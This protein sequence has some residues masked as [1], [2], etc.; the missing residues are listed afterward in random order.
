MKAKKK[1]KVGL[2][3]MK[4][5]E[6]SFFD[7]LLISL[8]ILLILI[9]LVTLKSVVRDTS[10]SYRFQRQIFWDI[11]ALGV[12]FYIIFEKESRLKTYG[13]YL[14]ALSVLLLILVL[15]IGKT[16]YGAKRWIDIGPFDLQPSELFKFSI[17]LLL[18]NIFSK[19]KNNKAFLYSIFAVFPAFLVF[20][21]PDLGMTLLVLFVWFVMLLA[22][23]VDRRYIF[24]ILLIG[25]LLA[26]ISFFFVLKDYQRARIISLFNPE[27]HFQYGAYNVI[28]SKVVIANGGLFGTGYGLGTGTNMHIV[29]MQ[30][31]DFIFSAYAEQF[32][33]IGSLVLILI[34]GTIIFG[35]LLRIGRYK[36]SFWEYVSIG[37]SS[38]FTF[39]VIENIGMNL[40][41]LPVTGIPLPF[42]SYGGTSTVIFGALIGLL[43]KARLVSK[44]PRPIY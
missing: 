5:N 21:E 3:N 31:T 23:D 24:L 35:G 1:H 42:I 36:D 29:P 12:M 28:M 33:M 18:S 6:F 7:Y 38:I 39:H 26:P 22:S 13:K 25:I 16:V 30:Y 8:V 10:Q 32:G 41:I 15:L 11:V 37:V 34:Y 4:E 27:E 43:I 44:I 20:L 40:G 19:Q 14:Y 9:G 17:V 2:E